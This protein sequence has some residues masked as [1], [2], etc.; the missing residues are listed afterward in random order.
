M[1]FVHALIGT[2]ILYCLVPVLQLVLDPFNNIACLKPEDPSSVI[3]ISDLYN[4]IYAYKNPETYYPAIKIV[5]VD[6]CKDREEIAQAIRKINQYK[7]SIIGID[8]RFNTAIDGKQDS[9]LKE[10][11]LECDNVVLAC[12]LDTDSLK[13]SYYFYDKI[14]KPEGF[15]N[16]EGSGGQSIIRNFI[17]S[18]TGKQGVFY[19]FPAEIVRQ[20]NPTKFKQLQ[21]Q[22]RIELINYKPMKFDTVSTK[23]LSQYENEIKG[24]IV[25][26]GAFQDDWH[27]TPIEPQMQGVRIHAY[28]LATMLENS[29]IKTINNGWV[30]I[31]T[32]V[33]T[34]FFVLACFIFLRKMRGGTSL[35]IRILQLALLMLFLFLGYILFIHFHIN[36]AYTKLLI[37]LGFASLVT[38]IYVGILIYGKQIIGKL[39]RGKSSTY[40]KDI[41]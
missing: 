19:S 22:K 29:S 34:Y 25:L 37:M 11:L 10:S 24:N 33:I 2:I 30:K 31:F 7:P 23:Y 3:E 9:I 20:I 4:I 40:E 36:I 39:I 12:W 27:N 5:Y 14:N 6:D 16:L 41:I 13:H 28:T 35:I 8:L 1:P 21:T 32:F 26:V 38:D 18:I 17:P 15:I